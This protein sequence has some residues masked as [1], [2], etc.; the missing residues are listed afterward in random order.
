MASAA[1]NENSCI[2]VWAKCKH[3]QKQIKLFDPD[4]IKRGG[5]KHGF[6]RF[7]DLDNTGKR[8]V[9]YKCKEARSTFGIP[10]F[11]PICN[12]QNVYKSN[13]GN[14]GRCTESWRHFGPPNTCEKCMQKCAFGKIPQ[15]WLCWRSNQQNYDFLHYMKQNAPQE[16]SNISKPLTTDTDSKNS[17]LVKVKLTK[18]DW[19]TIVKECVKNCMPLT[20][21]AIRYNVSIKVIRRGIKSRGHYNNK[22]EEGY[23]TETRRAAIVKLCVEESV[24]PYDLAIEYAKYNLSAS[25]IKS[26][27]KSANL[28]KTSRWDKPLEPDEEPQEPNLTLPKPVPSRAS[29]ISETYG[30]T[31][32]KREF[33][34]PSNF[35]FRYQE[36]KCEVDDEMSATNVNLKNVPSQLEIKKEFQDPNNFKFRFQEVKSEIHD[37][38]PAKKLK[39][40]NVPYRAINDNSATCSSQSENLPPSWGWGP[41]PAWGVRPPW[42]ARASWGPRPPWGPQ[43]GRGWGPNPNWK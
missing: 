6:N 42:G 35:E 24:S 13:N 7:Y 27:I 36:I 10:T 8:D 25:A 29:S 4:E 41:R 40:E 15:C 34:D 38:V 9:C 26:W 31:E 16:G 39:L 2:F 17:D 12:V 28:E 19:A 30:Q 20:E 37:E 43:W 32:I 22:M 23:F 14:C 1:P 21:I 33:Q 3:C 18:S 11:C 5:R